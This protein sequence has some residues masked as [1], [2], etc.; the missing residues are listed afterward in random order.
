MRA[1]KPKTTKLRKAQSS[2]DHMAIVSDY[3]EGAMTVPEI[4][5]AHKTSEENVGLIVSRHWKALTN[6]RESR[7]LLGSSDA[8]KAKVEQKNALEILRNTSLINEEF[9]ALLSPP[10]TALLSDS[11]AIYCWHLVHSGNPR[12]ALITSGLDVGLIRDKKRETRYSFDRSLVLRSQ[13]LNAKP[14]VIAYITQ[15]REERLINADVGKSLVQSELLDQL[16]QMKSS[17]DPARNRTAILRTIEL[18]GKTVGAFVD[19]VE[20]SEVNPSNALDK[21]IEMAQEAEV[22]D[23]TDSIEVTQ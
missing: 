15:L 4:A 6:V 9:L 18:L 22:S 11:E 17:A 1:R 19:R 8:P 7:L 13:Y 2:L 20:V 16:D 12:E 3:A 21:L 23:V 5:K 10:D 14:N